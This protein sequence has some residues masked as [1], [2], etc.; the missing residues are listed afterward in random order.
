MRILMETEIKQV[1]CG[2]NIEQPRNL[3]RIW[4]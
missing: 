3:G 4:V 2:N 1:N